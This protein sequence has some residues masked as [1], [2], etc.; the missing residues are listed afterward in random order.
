[1]AALA[2]ELAAE[3]EDAYAAHRAD[4]AYSPNPAQVAQRSLKNVCLAYLAARDDAAS[5]ALAL[6]QFDAADNMTDVDRRAGRA[7]RHDW[8][9]RATSRWRDSRRDGATIRW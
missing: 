7:E 2:R 4:G 6:A 9:T 5:H 8:P 1:M 3:F